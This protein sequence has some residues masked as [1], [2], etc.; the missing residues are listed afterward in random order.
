[1]KMT[2]QLWRIALA[3]SITLGLGACGTQS[4]SSSSDS[5]PS[6]VSSSSSSSAP[7]PS[8]SSSLSSSSSSSSANPA[9]VTPQPLPSAVSQSVV[10][11]V[12]FIEQGESYDQ[13]R[14]DAIKAQA[15]TMQ[16]YWHDQFDGTFYLYDQVVD[17]IYADHDPDYY[18]NTADGIHGDPRW[19]RLGNIQTE[20]Y[21][22]L[23]I[24]SFDNRVRVIN[25]PTTRIDGHVGAN[26][27]GAWMDG[28]DLG[29]LVGENNGVN[30]PYPDG[31]A[32]H[33]LGHV[34]HEFGH[35][36][37]LDHTG[38]DNDCMRFGF[39]L[40]FNRSE[41]C[42]F[43]QDNRNIVK[44]GSQNQAFLAADPG[45]VVTPQGFVEAR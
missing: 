3:S 1:M 34:S 2:N 42:D 23:G 8:S 16:Q 17:V 24:R 28:D 19:Y 45:H 33:C 41:M 36:Y 26:F 15:F 10:R 29:C 21:S 20:V 12:Y 35:V 14:F 40:N 37:G 30:F 5:S 39:Y 9:T 4:P 18:L 22:K 25:Y 31:N 6:S 27:G 38:P 11:F 7:A 13:A 44:S 43:S 32:A